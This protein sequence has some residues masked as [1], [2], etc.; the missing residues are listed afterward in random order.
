MILDLVT[1]TFI[2]LTAARMVDETRAE[3]PSAG[4]ELV[5]AREIGQVRDVLRLEGD[6]MPI[7]PSIRA[8]LDAVAAQPDAGPGPPG[9]AG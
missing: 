6:G 5:A 4:K 3:L 8:A 7:H 1:V 2:D 9:P